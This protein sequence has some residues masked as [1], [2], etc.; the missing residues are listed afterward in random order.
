MNAFLLGGAV[1]ITRSEDKQPM[2][3][4]LRPAGRCG[5]GTLLILIFLLIPGGVAAAFDLQGH[6]GARGLAPENTMAA[7]A[8]A[9]SLG[10]TTLELDLGVSR[11][12][13]L[14]VSHDPRLNPNLTRDAR[15]RWIDAP[16]PALNSLSV[17]ELK[18]YDVGRLKFGTRYALGFPQQQ[19]RDG[20]R[21]PTLDEVFEQCAAWGANDIRF[22]IETKLT[23]T[24]P[25]LSPVPEVFARL[26]VDTVRRH[27]MA[28]RTT[29]Q[30]F[31]WRTLREVQRL[32]PEIAIVALTARQ[33]WLDN[34]SDGR[35]TAGLRLADHDYSMPR[36]VKALGAVAWSPFHGDIDET[37]VRE[38]Q[39]LGLRVIPWTVNDPARIDQL[40]DWKVD[41]LISDHPERVRFALE[42]R[43]W[44]LPQPVPDA[45]F[46][47]RRD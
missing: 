24:E 47:G 28:A 27:R 32:A 39:A 42:R 23:P 16:G 20:E 40:L 6:R 21:I 29:V 26:V 13:V 10:V 35:W 38:A 1:N 19:P 22:N 7:F 3:L 46:H 15:G 37:A 2:V 8:T 25:E 45:R 36:Q 14:V 43:R 12:G 4:R 34:L 44:P 33:S 17:A 41:G 11:D 9:I 5:C 31:D 30:S 18:S